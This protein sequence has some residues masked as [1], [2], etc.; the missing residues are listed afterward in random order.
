MKILVIGDSCK[1][2]FVYCAVDRFCPEVP[3]PILKIRE[4]AENGGMS[5]N[6]QKN[7]KSL[8]VE[9]DLVTNENWEKMTK[10][11]YVHR[12]SNHM[13]LRI[14]T[15]DTATRI[16][17]SKISYNYDIIVIS[18]YNKGFLTE[19]DIQTICENHKRVFVDT[20]K[21]LGKWAEYALYIKINDTEFNSSKPYMSRF[22]LKKTIHTMGSKGAELDG[23]IYPVEPVE[24][25]DSSG[26]GDTFMAGLVVKYLKT[27]NIDESIKFANE[28]A[29]QVVQHRGVVSI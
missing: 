26:A 4:S 7:I 20:K 17:M 2:I 11:R 12:E 25:K 6:V 29:R 28:C 18:D 14:D 5:M 19:R 9:C 8:N 13:F 24:V 15:D 3:V 23:K 1:D 21:I 27:S 10:S 22:L 16:D